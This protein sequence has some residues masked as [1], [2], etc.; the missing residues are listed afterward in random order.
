MGKDIK[1]ESQWI[2]GKSQPSHPF[3]FNFSYTEKEDILPEL[4]Q[5]SNEVI[6][7]K[8]LSTEPSTQKVLK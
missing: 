8:A 2:L 4:L 6:H 3:G 1:F 5:E 7:V